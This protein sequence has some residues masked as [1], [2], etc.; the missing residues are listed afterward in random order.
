MIEDVPEQT[1]ETGPRSRSN[2]RPRIAAAILVVSGPP[3]GIGAQ[4]TE[5]IAM[6]TPPPSWSVAAIK[7]CR[8]TPR[9]ARMT[10]VMLA[11]VDALWLLFTINRPPNCRLFQ[12]AST[13]SL[14]AP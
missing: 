12:S 11:G 14:G 7:R 4:G 9:I 2:P 13:A 10:S 3:T 8:S 1:S 6:Q 5:L